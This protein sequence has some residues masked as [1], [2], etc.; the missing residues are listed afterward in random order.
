MFA[1]ARYLTEVR[2]RADDWRAAFLR[3]LDWELA[4][5]VIYHRLS[6]W[7]DEVG[8]YELVD[9]DAVDPRWLPKPPAVD[10][11]HL[12]PSRGF[13]AWTMIDRP[14][15]AR[16]FGVAA[17]RAGRGVVLD[18]GTPAARR[19]PPTTLDTVMHG[20]VCFPASRLW[21]LPDVAAVL[22]YGS[23]LLLFTDDAGYLDDVRRAMYRLPGAPPR[24]AKGS[25]PH[26]AGERE[27]AIWRYTSAMCAA[28]YWFE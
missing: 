17:G 8:L 20:T 1:E 19:E 23:D 28:G 10:C 13:L 15:D 24:G 5:G 22:K 9:R 26:L 14:D 2:S 18:R 7:R 25:P 27:I 16:A 12:G 4:D 11:P 21:F 3:E 6:R